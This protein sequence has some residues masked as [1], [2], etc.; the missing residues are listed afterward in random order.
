MA[1]V[2]ASSTVKLSVT[3][4]LTE[5]EAIALNEMTK[6]GIE[7]FLQGYYKYLGKH[8]ME[9][10]EPGMRSLFKTIDSE[11]PEHLSRINK[12]RRVFDMPENVEPPKCVKQQRG[13]KWFWSKKSTTNEPS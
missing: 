4:V 6:Y 8:Y 10:H 1:E 2:K 5:Q 13:G 12:A 3:V 9:P 11:L 7:P